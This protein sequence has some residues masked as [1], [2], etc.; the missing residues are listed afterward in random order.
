MEFVPRIRAQFWLRD[1]LSHAPAVVILGPR[2]VGKSTL[3]KGHAASQ[4]Q[5]AVYLDMERQSDFRKLEDPDVFLRPEAGKLIV[6]DE[7]H[8]APGLF[9][10][11]RGIIDDRRDTGHRTGQFLLLGS[12]SLDLMKQAS[13]TLAGR[14]IYMD[15]DPIGIRDALDANISVEGLWFR[16]GFPESLTAASHEDSLVWR[17]NFILSYL[18]RDVPMF[19]PRLPSEKIGRL[20]R[21]LAHEQGSMLNTTSL[22]QSLGVSVPTV[23]NYVD[24]LVDLKL[25]RRLQPWSGNIGKRLVKTPKVYVRDSGIVHALLEIESYEQLLGHMVCGGSWEGF[26]IENLVEA[27]GYREP[28]FYRTSNGAEVD[29]IFEK[30]G[31]PFVAIEIKRSSNPKVEPGFHIACEDLQIPHRI[32]VYPGSD[33][34]NIRNGVIIEPLHRALDRIEHL[35]DERSAARKKRARGPGAAS[36][37]S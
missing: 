10:E 24:L 27:A 29:L 1:A 30:A 12:A 36:A 21:M 3:A 25:V 16:G 7:I 34:W 31:K 14:V 35:L 20:W 2:Q 18:E 26:A 28:Y 6:I 17:R 11:L 37:L 13:E 19:A 32:C 33:S 23:T 9:P 5:E 15:L 8:R 22:A 4:G